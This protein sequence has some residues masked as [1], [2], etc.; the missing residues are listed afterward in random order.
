[1]NS[2]YDVEPSIRR[3]RMSQ[4]FSARVPTSLESPVGREQGPIDYRRDGE[5]TSNDGTSPEQWSREELFRKQHQPYSRGE[6]M[7]KRLP[8]LR[9]HNQNGGD[10]IVEED[11]RNTACAVHDLK[12]HLAVLL[13]TLC[14][15]AP[16]LGRAVLVGIDD[17]SVEG[18]ELGRD[19]LEEILE[20]VAILRGL[21]RNDLV[22]K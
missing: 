9:M 16:E 22:R 5:N 18:P 14:K 2:V 8:R 17:P 6:E 20:H 7:R 15:V 1:M 4:K 10:I 13:V 21:E 12:A 19:D 3:V 11:T